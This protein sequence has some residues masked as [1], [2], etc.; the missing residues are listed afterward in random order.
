MDKVLESLLPTLPPGFVVPGAII[1]LFLIA[2]PALREI[3]TGVIPSYRRYARE[4][5][6][7]ELLK[8]YYEVEAIKTDHQLSEL[9]PISSDTLR[10]LAQTT[11]T[12]LNA[13]DGS[14][15][16]EKETTTLSGMRK[17]GFGALG[18][19]VVSLLPFLLGPGLYRLWTSTEAPRLPITF[20]FFSLIVN[21]LFFALV[22]SV[23]AWATNSKTPGDALV[24][25]MTVTL[26]LSLL[27]SSWTRYL[28]ESYRAT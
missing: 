13:S 6:R 11:R 17:F 12:G 27:S 19:L 21:G 1:L 2:W 16:Y 10:A 23:T 8:L 15:P 22:G 3:W 20:V 5:R 24:R 7:L 9:L 28:L 26:V 18:G 25:G 4:K 14:Q